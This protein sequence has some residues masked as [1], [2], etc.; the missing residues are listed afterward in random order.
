MQFLIYLALVT[1]FFVASIDASMVDY[2]PGSYAS[3]SLGGGGG[4]RRPPHRSDKGEG[5]AG[6]RAEVRVLSLFIRPMLTY[7]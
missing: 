6:H 1:F 3:G 7:L 4:G 5:P 2:Q